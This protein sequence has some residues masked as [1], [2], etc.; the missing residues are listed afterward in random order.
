MSVRCESGLTVALE[1]LRQL[2]LLSF[3]VSFHHAH[4][5]F[6][7]MVNTFSFQTG[8]LLPGAGPIIN[9]ATKNVFYIYIYIQEK[10]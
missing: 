4:K 7:F 3:R 1:T 9:E 10:N 2:E 8:V 5:T 6:Y